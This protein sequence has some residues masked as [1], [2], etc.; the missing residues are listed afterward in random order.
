MEGYPEG[1]GDSDNKLID[2]E[3]LFEKQEAG[4]EFV[5]TQLFYDV[6]GFVEW[7]RACRARGGFSSS[8]RY[9]EEL[10]AH[11]FRAGITIPILPGIMPIQNYQSF[12]RMTNLCKSFIPA[13]ILHGLE[14]IQVRSLPTFNPGEYESCPDPRAK[15]STTTP[16]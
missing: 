3:Y 9:T 12:R 7:Y 4:A 10:V 6:E 11:S 13:D 16:P 5:V 8:R 2:I 14:L 1:H 15:N